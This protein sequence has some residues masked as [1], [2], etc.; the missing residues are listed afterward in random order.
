MLIISNTLEAP[1]TR[2]QFLSGL[3]PLPF[4]ICLVPLLGY[5]FGKVCLYFQG[6]YIFFFS[7]PLVRFF[8]GGVGGRYFFLFAALLINP[9]FSSWVYVRFTFCSL[10]YDILTF[11]DFKLIAWNFLIFSVSWG[12]QLYQSFSTFLCKFLRKISMSRLILLASLRNISF[13]NSSSGII[14]PQYWSSDR[15]QGG[16]TLIHLY[17]PPMCSYH[18]RPLL[19]ISKIWILIPPSLSIWTG[20]I[21][22]R[23]FIIYIGL[24]EES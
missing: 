16:V 9:I 1:T 17:L 21:F 5:F 7:L 14:L 22:I 18:H 24:I 12:F 4:P 13:E 2:T 15:E 19:I 20:T 3:A 23:T 11:K 8:L 10:S 6:S